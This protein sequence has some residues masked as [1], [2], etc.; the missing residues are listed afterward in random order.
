MIGWR[1][2][3]GPPHA[4]TSLA[5]GD[6]GRGRRVVGQAHY[7]P[8]ETLY[9]VRRLLWCQFSGAVPMTEKKNGLVAADA[10]Q[11]TSIYSKS[12]GDR[13]GSIEDIVIDRKT[14]NVAYAIMSSGGFLG[15]A[16]RHHPLPWSM[17][18][19]DENL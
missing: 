6:D 3:A 5:A 4:A 13:L 11:G 17:L 7:R 8:V 1:F 18:R 12:T 15:F 16:G 14:G 9:S 19:Y 10:L 2:R